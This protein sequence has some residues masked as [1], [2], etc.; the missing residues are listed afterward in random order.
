MTDP[1]DEVLEGV[2]A[3]ELIV[4]SVDRDGVEDGALARQETNGE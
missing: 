2:E 4:T 1:E 3:G